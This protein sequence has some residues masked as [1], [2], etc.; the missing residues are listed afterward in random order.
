V[1]RSRVLATVSAAWWASSPIHPSPGIGDHG[2]CHLE[3]PTARTHAVPL[4]RRDAFD[5]RSVQQF[6]G[7]PVR[8]S[9]PSQAAGEPV[10][11]RS[12]VVPLQAGQALAWR[13]F[14][15]VRP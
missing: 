13:L 9:A 8:R 14:L 6:G 4:G 5:N 11:V 2:P 15:P 3:W 12:L 1:A 7:E 10:P